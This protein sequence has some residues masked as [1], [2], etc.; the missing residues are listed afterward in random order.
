MKRKH[1]LEL[2]NRGRALKRRTISMT[3]STSMTTTTTT[4]GSP[5]M[6]SNHCCRSHAAFFACFHFWQNAT[7]YEADSSPS[8]SWRTRASCLHEPWYARTR[9]G[10]RFVAGRGPGSPSSSTT[11]TT[12]KRYKAY[13]RKAWQR[14]H[15]KSLEGL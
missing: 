12:V 11:S 14:L 2:Q 3:T 4:P 8:Q 5:S 6:V 15:G 7:R 1:S 10:W 13:T 9:L